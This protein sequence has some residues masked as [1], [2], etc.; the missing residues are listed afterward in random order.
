MTNQLLLYMAAVVVPVFFP[1]WR[2]AVLGLGVQGLML[3]LTLLASHEIDSAA[4]VIE[5]V[6]LLL[7]RAVFV[8]WYLLRKSGPKTTSADFSL[9]G[10]T[11]GERSL[12]LL[13][14][15]CGF[16]AG[17]VMGRGDA[18][19]IAQISTA[20]SSLLIG[21]LMIAN[22]RHPAAQLVGL[23]TFEGGVTL[24][25]MLSPHAMPFPVQL[26]VSAIDVFFVLTCGQYFTRFSEM[27]PPPG[28]TER[29]GT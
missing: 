14:L 27:A 11:L 1:S 15:A 23:F 16:G 8:P 2:V 13:L 21:M 3:S 9:V 24:V 10:T 18:R 29:E 28:T 20:V 7:I 19:E 25:E 26:G 12:V 6:C 4:V 22:Q 5:F 17:L